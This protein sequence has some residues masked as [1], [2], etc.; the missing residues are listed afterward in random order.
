[1]KIDRRIAPDAGSRPV[2]GMVARTVLV[3]A[4]LLVA[5]LL[6]T[7]NCLAFFADESGQAN[8]IT[9]ESAIVKLIDS[10]NVPAELPGV[11]TNMEFREGQ[12]VE[13]GKEIARIKNDE[14]SLKLRR[15]KI[16]N[17]ISRLTAENDIDL[18]FAEKS[19]EVSSAKVDRSIESNKRVPGVVPVSR[20]Q[21]QELEAHRDKLRVE[22]AARDQKTASMQ[23]ELS[24]TNV[25]LSELL[26]DKSMIRAPIAGMVVSVDAKSGEWVEPGDTIVKVVRMDRLKIEGS[27]PASVASRIR[28]GDAATAIVNQQWLRDASFKGQVVFINPEANPVNSNVKVW[29]EVENKD[30]K[31]I[32]GL[33]ATVTIETR[34]NQISAKN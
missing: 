16:E 30:L 5:V 7:G 1:M 27:V 4:I 2:I 3:S 20:I 14:L 34:R 33:E 15:A 22:Q 24:A 17:R 11:L 28:V 25:E 29:I 21:E 10:V 26:K 6:V 9:I 8:R 31:L 19:L 32:P 23:V 18:R 12:M 13:K